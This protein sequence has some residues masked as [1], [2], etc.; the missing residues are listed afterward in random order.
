MKQWIEVKARYDKVMENGAEKKEPSY[1]IVPA[2]S[3]AEAVSEYLIATK[4]SM[5]DIE[6]ESA[7]ETKYI[8]IYPYQA[9]TDA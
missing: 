5:C 8:D 7:G 6:I 3:L 9:E 1:I 4:D 2:N